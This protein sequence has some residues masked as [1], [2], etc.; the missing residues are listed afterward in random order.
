MYEQDIK[1]EGEEG[2]GGGSEGK[3]DMSEEQ[4]EEGDL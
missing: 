4:V 3:V 1:Q 2:R